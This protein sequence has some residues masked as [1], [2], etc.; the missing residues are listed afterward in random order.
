MI[1]EHA[2]VVATGRGFVW[3]EARRG[4]ACGACGVNGVC[5]MGVLARTMGARRN[6]VR[7]LND[8]ALNVG[9]LVVIGMREGALIKGSVAIY[10]MPLFFMLLGAFFGEHGIAD[11]GS[12]GEGAAILL[13]LTGLLGGLV[14]ARFSGRVFGTDSRYHPVVMKRVIPGTTRL[15]RAAE[16]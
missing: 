16:V 10:L 6:R 14:W 5:G 1:Q 4:S 9:D 13:G 8:M 11:S 3:V 15:S 2:R 7:V 12:D